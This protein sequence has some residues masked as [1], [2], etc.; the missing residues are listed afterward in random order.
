MWDNGRISSLLLKCQS[1]VEGA[2]LQQ[3]A[4]PAGRRFEGRQTALVF[5]LSASFGS[6]LRRASLVKSDMG[7]QH[8]AS[9]QKKR[10]KEERDGW[11]WGR[12]QSDVYS[13]FHRGYAANREKLFAA[14]NKSLVRIKLRFSLV[15]ELNDSDRLLRA[16]VDE[17]KTYNC[18]FEDFLYLIL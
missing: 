10:K 12:V 5:N 2:D 9:T 7:S 18:E 13:P 1:A 17:K 15:G 6:Y 11:W 4:S 14:F 16:K 8:F 3:A